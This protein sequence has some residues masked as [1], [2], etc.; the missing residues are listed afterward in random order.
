MA[1][2]QIRPATESTPPVDLCRHARTWLHHGHGDRGEARGKGKR[3]TGK[4]GKKEQIKKRRAI[5]PAA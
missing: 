5:W 1:M 2:K 3:G 4:T